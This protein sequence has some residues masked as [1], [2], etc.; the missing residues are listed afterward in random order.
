MNEKVEE[1]KDTPGDIAREFTGHFLYREMI[2]YLKE[3][4]S[5]Q[6][7]VAFDLFQS[8]SGRFDNPEVVASMEAE[9]VKK[10]HYEDF[11]ADLHNFFMR[12]VNTK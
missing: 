9:I 2:K 7:R 3:K 5:Q 6:D 8:N 10:A 12:K 4:I 1:K 11:L